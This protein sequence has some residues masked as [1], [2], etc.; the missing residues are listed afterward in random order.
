LNIETKAYLG[1][2]VKIL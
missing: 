2:I 1:M